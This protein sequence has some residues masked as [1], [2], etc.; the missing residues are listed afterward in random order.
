MCM[1]LI[2]N[3]TYMTCVVN[4]NSEEAHLVA[5]HICVVCSMVRNLKRND[6]QILKPWWLGFYKPFLN[7]KMGKINMVILKCQRE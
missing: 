3:H 5:T 1:L 7:S 4:V 2:N 6:N